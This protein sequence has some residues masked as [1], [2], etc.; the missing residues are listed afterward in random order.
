MHT[1]EGRA[2]SPRRENQ[3]SERKTQR[4]AHTHTFTHTRT[5]VHTHTHT[6]PDVFVVFIHVIVHGGLGEAVWCEGRPCQVG[7][8][9]GRV[10]VV[11]RKPVAGCGVDSARA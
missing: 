6:H 11:A 9:R 3:A 10:A 7:R 1:M 5:H 8:I 4:W 2:E